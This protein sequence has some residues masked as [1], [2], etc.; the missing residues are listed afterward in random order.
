MSSPI[1][2]ATLVF[3]VYGQNLTSRLLGDVCMLFSARAQLR[4]CKLS[5]DETRALLHQYP[6]TL[7]GCVYTKKI[8]SHA[9]LSVE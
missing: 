8:G 3:N 5:E 6:L 9:T 1:C 2:V 7:P 4:E